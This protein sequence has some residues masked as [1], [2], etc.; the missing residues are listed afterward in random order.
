MNPFHIIQGWVNDAIKTNNWEKVSAYRLD[1][2]K[3]CPAYDTVGTSC[4]VPGTQPCCSS[5]GCPL[6]KKSRSDSN[7]PQK[8]W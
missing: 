2:C 6:N 3:S 7:C 4:K 5:C 1:I 8:K